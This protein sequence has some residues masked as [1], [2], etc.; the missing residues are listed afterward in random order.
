[1]N[2]RTTPLHEAAKEGNF[3]TVETLLA[4]GADVNAKDEYGNT[5]LHEAATWSHDAIAKLLLKK[6]ANVNA[7]A[8]FGATPLHK[9]AGHG[10]YR[11]LSDSREVLELLLAN[12]ADVNARDAHGDTPL[13]DAAAN[14]N[15]RNEWIEF[16]VARGADVHAKNNDGKT[17]LD[18]AVKVVNTDAIAVLQTLSASPQERSRMEY[19]KCALC[20]KQRP[21]HEMEYFVTNKGKRWFCADSCWHQAKYKVF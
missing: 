15:G 12:G 8:K 9:A 11:T 6:G 4:E 7:K 17:P 2:E 1:M 19:L 20:G 21:Q 14:T 10:N 13:H 3:R 16:L 18:I 5:P